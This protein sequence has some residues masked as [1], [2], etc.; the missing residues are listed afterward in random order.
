MEIGFQPV[1]YW[2][3][4][5][6]LTRHLSKTQIQHLQRLTGFLHWFQGAC[7]FYFSDNLQ[8]NHQMWADSGS[9]SMKVSYLEWPLVSFSWNW[10]FLKEQQ[11]SIRS[12]SLLWSCVAAPLLFFSAPIAWYES[13]CRCKTYLSAR[14]PCCLHRWVYSRSLRT[15][16]FFRLAWSRSSRWLAVPDISLRIHDVPFPFVLA[17]ALPLAVVPLKN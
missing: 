2:H 15:S 10:I 11:A 9:F 17:A 5:V 16:S 1:E 6:C 3:S 7:L 13:A 8:S 14:G 12:Q 4:P